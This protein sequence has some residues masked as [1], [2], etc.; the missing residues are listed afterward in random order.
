MF[1]THH[2]LTVKRV[3]QLFAAV[4]SDS[5][6]LKVVLQSHLSYICIM[7]VIKEI[8]RINANEFKAG[9]IGGLGKGSWHEKYKDSA[10]VYLGGMTF[11][12]SEGDIL[13]VMS[14][15]GEVEDINLVRDKA[16]NKSLGYAFV[17][18][19]DQRSTILAVDNFNGIKLLG[20]TLRCDHVD[21]YKL[22]KDVRKRE[23]DRLDEDPEAEPDVGPGHAYNDQEMANG[24]SI[25]QGTDVWAPPQS[26]STASVAPEVN[27]SPVSD[28][29]RR[30]SEKVKKEKKSK[31]HH[32]DHSDKDREKT[33]DDRKERH[34]DRYEDKDDR[35]N[36][37][38][39]HK[40][41]NKDS[42]SSSR[43]R[44]AGGDHESHRSDRRKTLDESKEI[45]VPESV[46]NRPTK[47]FRSEFALPQFSAGGLPR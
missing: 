27:D 24:F 11:E 8:E 43:N 1:T 26:S 29:K 34:R 13:C 33:T 32:K 38:R 14:Q 41:S 44:A 10:W 4:T 40:E 46:E 15:W 22:S 17:K 18:Y 45:V 31:K 47:T 19:E 39:S 25:K 23:E 21:K 42:K 9:I 20:R 28:G 5:I 12:L 30:K 35:R 37:H 3:Q 7:N 6:V 16:T 36:H 2:S